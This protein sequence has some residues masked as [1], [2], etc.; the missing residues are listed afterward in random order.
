MRSFTIAVLPAAVMALNAGNNLATIDDNRAV[1]LDGLVRLPVEGRLGVA[2][3]RP[4]R[5]QHDVGI[6]NT[7]AGETYLMTL[8]MG[9]PGK[10][11]SVEI[12]TGSHELWVNPDCST[13]FD[14][15]YCNARSRY[16]TSSS[17]VPLHKQGNITYGTDTGGN[18]GV[19]FDYVKDTVSVGSA[20]IHNQIFGDAYK[21]NL[22]DVGIMGLGPSL[23]G[24]DTPEYPMV[25][26]SLAQ[27][28]LT[29]GRA[30]SLD[31]RAMNSPRGSMIFGGADTKKFQGK[32]VKRPITA[33]LDNLP[34]Y[35]VDI[36]GL[37]IDG[38][39]ALAKGY[40]QPVVLDSGA[41]LS[42]LPSGL[43]NN[44]AAAFPGAEYLEKYNQWAVP[45]DFRNQDK[46][47]DFEFGAATIKV[48]YNDFIWE[49]EQGQ[50]YL[51]V[52]G[53]KPGGEFS[54]FISFLTIQDNANMNPPE[55]R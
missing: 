12:D 42:Y 49:P 36:T 39:L 53:T 6:D 16:E 41:G 29:N 38:R 44:L 18:S 2:V 45:C 33:G 10:D 30:F 17:T 37:S 48:S 15:Q 24:W 5:R 3:S 50:C 7:R 32:L 28:G 23:N 14:K 52:I 26:D 47:V 31:L 27:Q 22:C 34:R 55:T 13:A 21:S 8:K 4:H 9:T 35:W 20:T 25:V 40:S 43:V 54:F 19:Y 51:G 46:T 11:V 1:E